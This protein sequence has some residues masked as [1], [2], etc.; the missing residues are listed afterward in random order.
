MLLMSFLA[1]LGWCSG[2]VLVVVV[3]VVLVGVI[4]IRCL[5]LSWFVVPCALSWVALRVFVLVVRAKF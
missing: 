4:M 3:L 1:S 2:V 5:S